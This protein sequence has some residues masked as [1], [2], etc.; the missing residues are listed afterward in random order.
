MAGTERADS[1]TGKAESDLLASRSNLAQSDLLSSRSN[2]APVSS[3]ELLALNV[4]RILA[5]RGMTQA[6]LAQRLGWVTN[7][8]NNILCCLNPVSLLT[9]D[10]IAKALQTSPSTLLRHPPK[11][12][13]NS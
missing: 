10:K 6:Q 11:N 1:L 4:R 8:V 12:S 5:K 9:L 13:E 3:A 7:R 2:S